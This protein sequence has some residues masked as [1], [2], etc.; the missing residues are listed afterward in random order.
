MADTFPPAGPTMRTSTIA[1]YLYQQYNDD[2]DLQAFVDAYNAIAQAY[3]DWFINLDLPIYTK[4]SGDLLDWVA[5]GLYGITRPY[6]PSGLSRNIG[7]FDTYE[8]N[9]LAFDEQKIIAPATY[10]LTNDDVFKRIITWNFYKGDGNKFNIRWLKRRVVRFLTGTNGTAGETDHTYQVSVTFGTNY[11][12]NIN[13]QGTLRVWTGGAIFNRQA[14]NTFGFNQFKTQ[15][16]PE[17]TS[18]YAP[19][20]KAAVEAGVLQLPFQ[21]TYVVNL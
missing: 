11:Q 17:V 1:S 2:S 9:K 14:L 12:V 6:L 5:A 16:V 10:Y 8:Y 20:F 3:V 18:P 15:A 4:Q 13:L 7:A 19:I 21:F